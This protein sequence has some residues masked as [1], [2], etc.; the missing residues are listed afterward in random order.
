MSGIFAVLHTDGSLVNADHLRQATEAMAFRGPDAQACWH[1]GSTGLGHTLLRTVDDTISDHQ[2]TEVPGTASRGVRI[3]AHAR[4]DGQDN[5]RRRLR[6]AGQEPGRDTTDAQLILHAYLAWGEACLDHLLGDFTFAIWDE[7]RQVLFCARD[8]FGIRP[9]FYAHAGKRLVVSNTMQAVRLHPDVPDDLDKLYIA[10]FLMFNGTPEPLTT[11]FAHIRRLAPGHALRWSASAGV[12]VRRYWSLPDYGEERFR[13]GGDYVE[14]FW[15]ALQ[16]S[17]SD[18]LRTRRIGVQLSGGMD[19]TALAATARHVLQRDT[20]PYEL[21]GLCVGSTG[22]TEDEEPA[23][24]QATADY[25]GMPLHMIIND[26]YRLMQPAPMGTRSQPEPGGLARHAEM[27]ARDTKATA[28]AR[29][30]LTGWDGDALLS[31]SIRPRLMTLTRQ[32]RY[33]QLLQALYGLMRDNGTL[34]ARTWWMAT[35]RGLKALAANKSQQQAMPD[36]PDWLDTD[37]ECHLNLRERWDAVLAAARMPPVQH[38]TRPFAYTLLTHM[39]EDARLFDR[40]DAGFIGQPVEHR[41]PLMD[42]RLVEFSLTLPLQPWVMKKHVLRQA[43]RGLLP[44]RVRRRPKTPVTNDPSV[45][46]MYRDVSYLPTWHYDESLLI[47]FVKKGILNQKALAARRASWS[48]NPPA[49]VSDL[50]LIDL[51]HWLRSL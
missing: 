27:T 41:H 2:P 35:R 43:M 33:A 18:R 25:L 24:A 31:E 45:A 10:D 14:A 50:T 42:L 20:L 17:V 34:G 7:H 13:P 11:P 40:Q 8:H 4:I 16:T 46:L 3:T 47:Q 49:M 26:D 30:W 5:L 29:V 39:C 32:R 44:E 51:Q 28:L 21:L 19:S 36:Y 22:L 23:Y 37:L 38:P 6:D 9:L 12:Q 1:A 15:D 48:S